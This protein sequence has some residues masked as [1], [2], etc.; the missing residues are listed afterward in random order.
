MDFSNSVPDK[1]QFLPLF[2]YDVNTLEY[3]TFVFYIDLEI[4]YA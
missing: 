2:K 3:D 4:Q 1:L